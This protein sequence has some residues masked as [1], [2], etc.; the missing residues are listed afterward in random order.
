MTAPHHG[1]EHPD[2]ELLI[3]P[4]RFLQ[5]DGNVD[6]RAA[7][8]AI[9]LGHHQAKPAMLA[10]GGVGFLGRDAVTVALLHIIRRA[11]TREQLAY[12]VA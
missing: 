12:L 8:A 5:Q 7:G 9:L 4:T 2:A 3:G 10:H 6:G 1:A 11:N